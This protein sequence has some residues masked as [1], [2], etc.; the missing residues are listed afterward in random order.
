M[1]ITNS[2]LPTIIEYLTRNIPNALGAYVLQDDGNGDGIYI[3]QWFE[4]TL[5]PQPTEAEIEAAETDAVA[6]SGAPKTI[7][8]VDFFELLPL[9][10]Q[11]AISD[12][13]AV[14]AA[15]TPPVT[16]FKMMIDRTNSSTAVIHL[17]NPAV[18]GP[19]GYIK[20]YVDAL[21]SANILT[22][23]QAN[24]WMQLKKVT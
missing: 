5:G 14:K 24:D 4:P 8:Y 9:T 12:F 7:R 18:V 2:N 13:A 20:S 17:D 15:E 11:E 23:A 10:I 3:A 19:T 1:A 22:Q 16:K 6:W 21:V